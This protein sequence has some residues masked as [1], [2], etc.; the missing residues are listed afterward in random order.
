MS[1][2]SCLLSNEKNP[3]RSAMGDEILVLAWATAWLQ[4]WNTI[5]KCTKN[6]HLK[7]T[8]LTRCAFYLNESII[9]KRKGENIH[10]FQEAYPDH[11]TP[12]PAEPN[13][14]FS[15]PVSWIAFIVS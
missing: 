4:Q 8:H 3:E 5:L 10:I 7:W 14:I 12:L 1:Y 6:N 2:L 9:E 11:S 13:L 15:G